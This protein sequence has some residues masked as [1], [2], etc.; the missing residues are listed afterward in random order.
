[1]RR[2]HRRNGLSTLEMVLSLPILL[3]MMALMINFGTVSSWKVRGWLAARHAAWQS[4][5]PRNLGDFP[6]PDY[7]PPSAS[8]GAGGGGAVTELDDPAV[9]QPVVRGPWLLNT[10]VDESLFDPVRGLRHG[11]SHLTR[12]YPLLGRLGDYH[13]STQTLL[14]DNKW[15]FERFGLSSTRQR[16][17]PVLYTFPQTDASFA[18]AYLNAALAIYYAPFRP[19]LFPLDRDDEFIGYSQRFGWGSGAPEFHPDL[20]NCCGLL[21]EDAGSCCHPGRGVAFCCR[22][23]AVAQELV[24]GLVDRI[25]GKVERDDDGNVVRRVPCVAERMARAFINLY[26]RVIRELQDQIAATPPPPAGEIASMQA[27]ISDLEAKIDT[28]NQYV[29]TLTN[30]P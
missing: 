16:R 10:Q 22:N 11:S 13:L 2:L 12:E 26:Q 14:L 4:R 21:D 29:E 9:D 25:Q 17:I 24:T 23:H 6:R 8:M 15:Q 18:D 5:W 3:F 28:L 30:A 19:D 7:W 27:E 1:M 20:Q